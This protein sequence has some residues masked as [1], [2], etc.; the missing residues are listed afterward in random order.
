MDKLQ[1]DVKVP[2]SHV[3]AE[4]LEALVQHLWPGNVR[5]LQNVVHRAMLSCDGNRITSEHLPRSLTAQ[6]LPEIPKPANGGARMAPAGE[7][8]V[9]LEELERRAIERAL[10]H[11]NGSVSK[12]ARLLGIGRATLYRRMASVRSVSSEGGQ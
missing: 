7:E 5:E 11:T 9:P 1:V 8:I 3:D 2:I 4:A 12:A 6:P 10:A